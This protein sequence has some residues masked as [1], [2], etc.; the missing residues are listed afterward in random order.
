MRARVRVRVRVRVTVKVPVHDRA[1]LVVGAGRV[2]PLGAERMRGLA[3]PKRPRVPDPLVVLVHE[4]GAEVQPAVR[5]ELLRVAREEP[6]DSA[7]HSREVVAVEDAERLVVV[8][9][10]A[11]GAEHRVYARRGRSRQHRSRGG[12]LPGGARHVQLSQACS[13]RRLQ[14][15]NTKKI[16][17]TLI[18][19]TISV[20]D[21]NEVSA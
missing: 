10:S 9:L 20:K 11:L 16:E 17:F 6:R 18:V 8:V 12:A 19:T 13:W 21:I 5:L 3:R 4:C 1:W 15:V 14:H 7:W 2:V